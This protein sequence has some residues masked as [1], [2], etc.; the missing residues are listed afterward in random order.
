MDSKALTRP[1]LRR[2]A[3]ALA[4]GL[5]LAAPLAQAQNFESYYGRPD[6]RD[7]GE[8][9]K[10][11]AQCPGGGSVTVATRRQGRADSAAQVLITR[12]DNDGVSDG[13]APG[14][15][16][17]AYPVAGAK[18]A[19]GLGIVE[20]A[21][22]QG[23]A[24][25]GTVRDGRVSRMFVMNVDCDGNVRWT[26]VLENA[27]AEAQATGYDLIQSAATASRAAGAGE[28][29]VVGEEVVPG[30]G[31]TFGRIARLDLGG[32]V[33]WDHRYD[34]R[35]RPALQFRAVAENLADSGAFSDLVVA[36]SAIADDGVHDALMLRTD[37]NGAPVCA[38]TLGDQR[39]H[40]DFHG[41]TP[42]LSRGFYGDTV[43]VGA[44]R[45]LS[46]GAPSRP[47][48]AR[49]GRGGCAVQAQ[50]DWYAPEKQG[51]TAFDAVE[52]REIDGYDGAVVVAGTIDGTQG[53][54]FAANPADLREYAAGPLA[55][56]YGDQK[57]E[58][59]Y[60][61]DRKADRFVLAGYT[62]AD[63]EG[64]GDAQDV[65]F[66][67]TDPVLKT[68]CAQD[69]RPQGVAL[70]LPYKELR[71][72]P[73]AVE[74]W[75]RPDTGFERASD[76]KLAC[77]RDPPSG[78]PGVIDNGTVMLGVHDNG[79]LNIECPAIKP[80]MGLY[81]TSLVGLRLMSTNGEASAPGAPCEGWGVANADPAMPVTGHTSRCGTTANV[82]AAPLTVQ[83]TAPFDRATSS[84]TVGTTFR[85]VHRFTPSP[86]T[87]FLYRVDVAIQNIGRTT[88]KDLRYTR[89]IDY[90][91]PP[92]T[93]SE[94]ITLAGSSPLLVGWNNNGFTTLDPLAAHPTTGPLADN[95]PGD[96]GS[97]MDFRLGSLEPGATRS[98]VTYY[99]AAPTEKQAL[100]ALSS[101]GAGLYS[102]GQPN[103]LIGSPWTAPV[104]G[105]DGPLLGVPNT[106]M[107]G[108][109]TR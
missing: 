25:T 71:P 34:G 74:K 86:L 7:G 109:E 67:Q 3:A 33:V 62:E 26:T 99:G 56:L 6:W 93:F 79:Y 43:L 17:R 64:A 85:V 11:V 23:F 22:R 45:G 94:Y 82:V 42:L 70:E 24:V 47:Y 77:D 83:P 35:E 29:V 105:P 76:W 73:K 69:W 13:G 54:T 38:A 103:Y 8:D 36:G 80:S 101:V 48:L 58:A 2:C 32:N 27:D 91:V 19:T 102:L 75:L 98:F 30:Q 15:W 106:F 31:R 84:V 61:I 66:V 104:P 95:G 87:P 90:D 28:I 78:C 39:E 4:A 40:R 97:H 108:L 52:A 59:I 100:G 37:G 72:E 5:L 10:S 92:N 14:T 53:F 41:L 12:M 18:Y 50:A 16:Q 44:A 57:R 88:V 51:F 60:A 63:R 65:Y 20:L 21:Q 1:G 68:R 107:Y 9:V 49:F 96:L 89:G 46:D 55:R 81:G